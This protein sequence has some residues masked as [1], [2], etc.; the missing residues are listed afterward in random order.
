MSSY[1]TPS[2]SGERVSRNIHELLDLLT[3][4]LP[5]FLLVT[6]DH[7]YFHSAM[8]LFSLARAI[9]R[10]EIDSE[11]EGRVKIMI[12]ES[13]SHRCLFFHLLCIPF[14]Q[15][16]KDASAPLVLPVLDTIYL[17]TERPGTLCHFESIK[18]YE[19][20]WSHHS[21]IAADGFELRWMRPSSRKGLTNT[22]PLA[23]TQRLVDTF[24]GLM[25][26]AGNANSLNP[27]CKRLLEDDEPIPRI[28]CNLFTDQ[29]A[30]VGKEVSRVD[31][32]LYE[33]SKTAL[34]H[35]CSIRGS[36]RIARMHCASAALLSASPA[37]HPW[38]S[39]AIR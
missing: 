7:D 28:I 33:N 37:R 36:R 17:H 14:R 6:G 29:L 25:R 31:L 30:V 5:R 10:T 24:F 2:M 18:P 19:L 15:S 27:E 35:P 23:G 4:L 26:I 12:M 38:K 11:P 32:G 9:I 3:P 39:C 1:R 21:P 22:S 13:V 20:D 16:A 8:K 34:K